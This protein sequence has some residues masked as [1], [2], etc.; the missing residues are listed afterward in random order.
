MKRQRRTSRGML[1]VYRDV[2]P[3]KCP[4]EL[5]DEDGD[6]GLQADLP[7]SMVRC[8]DSVARKKGVT[9]QTLACGIVIDG[10]ERLRWGQASL[11]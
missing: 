4:V 11:E 6:V 3:D 8:L 10:M 1:P 2:H 5:Y 7:A 9:F